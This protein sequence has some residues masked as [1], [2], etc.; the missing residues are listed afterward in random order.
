[1]NEE[2]FVPEHLESQILSARFQFMAVAGRLGV[3]DGIGVVIELYDGREILTNNLSS[4]AS[5]FDGY[6]EIML[7]GELP[8]DGVCIRHVVVC[9]EDFERSA[10]PATHQRNYEHFK[11]LLAAHPAAGDD[12]R[13]YSCTPDYPQTRQISFERI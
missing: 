1:M 3:V 6:D 9:Q 8:D 11:T 4:D 5:R 2:Y 13:I 10:D 7:V 12:V